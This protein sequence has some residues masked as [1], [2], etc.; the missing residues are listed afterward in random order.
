MAALFTMAK[1]WK[2]PR[3]PLTDEW[4]EKLWQARAHTHTH[5][6]ILLS[7]KRNE[8][9]SVVVKWMKLEPVIQ[10]EV[11]QTGEKQISYINTYIWNLEK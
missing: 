1:N 4:I 9:E 3:C 11:N 7:H 8:F 5:A 2:Q 10:S 6:G